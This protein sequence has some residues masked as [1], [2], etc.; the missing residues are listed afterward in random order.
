MGNRKYGAARRAIRGPRD[1]I[2]RQTPS[3]RGEGR[4]QGETIPDSPP[5]PVV[6]PN[7]GPSVRVKMMPTEMWLGTETEPGLIDLSP[8]E[9]AA[10]LVEFGMPEPSWTDE[11]ERR[12]RAMNPAVVAKWHL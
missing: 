11:D 2:D 5:A 3:E 8:E 9:R 4:A 7:G 10:A 12:W 1:L 6:K